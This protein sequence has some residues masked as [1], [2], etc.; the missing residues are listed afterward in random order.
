MSKN[1]INGCKIARKKRMKVV[2]LSGFQKT[3]LLNK[4]G[5][6]NIWINSKVYNIVENIHQIILLLLNDLTSLKTNQIK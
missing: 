3:N 4:K 2:T 1:I 6:I 5:D